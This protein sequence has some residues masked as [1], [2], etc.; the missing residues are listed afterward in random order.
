LHDHP[1]REATVT[2]MRACVE[3]ARISCYIS[4][5]GRRS[6]KYPLW[7]MAADWWRL[8]A[9]SQCLHIESENEQ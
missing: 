5:P 4:R 9:V 8:T 2:D 6:N 1:F 3:P 7:L